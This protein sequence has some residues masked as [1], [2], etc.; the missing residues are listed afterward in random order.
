MSSQ[1][2]LTRAQSEAANECAGQTT[3]SFETDVGMDEGSMIAGA[4]RMARTFLLRAFGLSRHEAA[5]V[6]AARLIHQQGRM[7]E[8]QRVLAVAV[9]G[10]MRVSG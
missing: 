3:T 10:G 7:P 8:P 1:A 9:G 6:A 5:E 4:G 2:S